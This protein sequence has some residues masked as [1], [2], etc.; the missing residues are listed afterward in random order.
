MRKLTASTIGLAVRILGNMRAK[1]ITKLRAQIHHARSLDNNPAIRWGITNEAR[2]IQELLRKIWAHVSP[3]G[4]WMFRNNNMGASHAC[5]I[6]ADDVSPKPLR[7]IEVKC[8]YSMCD[9][10]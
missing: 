10:S 8:P 3:T 5:I 2:A 9:I 6:Y 7:I 1:D 4:L